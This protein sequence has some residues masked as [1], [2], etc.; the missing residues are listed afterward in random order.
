MPVRSFQPSR[1]L[2]AVLS[3]LD[4]LETETGVPPLGETK[5]VDLRGSRRGSGF[6]F[7]R[8]GIEAYLHLLH[9]DASGVW[10]MELAAT[11]SLDDAAIES[12]V[13]RAAET[14]G[15]GILWW[16]FGESSPAN[17]ARTRF[18]TVRELHKLSG[19]LPI[20]DGERLQS[21]IEIRA[22]RP[23]QD[24]A[25]WLSV[26]NAAFA[27]HAENGAWTGS[28]LAERMGRPWFDAEGFRLAWSGDDL[29]GFCWTKRHSDGVGE[30]YVVAVDPGFQ[31]RG[32]GRAIVIDG[33]RYLA[34]TGCRTAML[35]VDAA[36]RSALALYQS[37]GF[38]EERIDRC[39]GVPKGWPHEA[40]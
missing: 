24:E 9:H 25:A 2:A 31:G 23:E 26:N 18:P 35:Y 16:V 36:N 17:F 7:E 4:R 15:T 37:L 11:S 1:D 8:D 33:L 20:T 27:D 13:G 29:A 40:Q 32:I 19:P 21:G 34:D 14:A 30:I 5:Y 28:D 22:F 6:V 10:E 12:L 39:V 38:T 3:L